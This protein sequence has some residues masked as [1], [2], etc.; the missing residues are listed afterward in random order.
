MNRKTKHIAI[1]AIILILSIFGGIALYLQEA[2]LPQNGALPQLQT[3]EPAEVIIDKEGYFHLYARNNPD[4]Y[5][6]LGYLH[7][8]RY[9]VK[10]DL[11]QRTA[12]GTLSEAF[13]ADYL[14]IDIFSRT[15]GFADIAAD[16]I[17]RIDPAERQ[18]MSAY[19][20]GINTYINHNFHR[21]P[22]KFKF[23]RYKPSYWKPED[24]LAI[25]RL[26]AWALSDQLTK[27]VV[28]YKLLEIYGAAKIRDGFPAVDNLPPITFPVHN[29]QF[30]AD[31][32]YFVNSH[33]KML[34]MLNITVEDLEN[35][36]ALSADRTV[37]N[38]PALGGELPDFLNDYHDLLELSA[39][40]IQ[41]SGL[42]IP[43]IP[44]VLTGSNADI[45]WNLTIRPGDNLEFILIPG[46]ENSG[47]SGDTPR[48]FSLRQERIAIRNAADTTITV[49]ETKFGPIIN[50]APDFTGND[51]ELAIYW[52]G[53][54][55]SNDLQCFTRLYSAQS[56][57]DFKDAVSWHIVPAAE[58]DYLDI[59]NNIG[60]AQHIS[61]LEIDDS[62]KRLYTVS[63]FYEPDFSN[64][65]QHL[66]RNLNPQSVFI[67]HYRAFAECLP[68]S[69]V[70]EDP[71]ATDSLLS[72]QEILSAKENR[73]AKMLLPL[74]FEIISPADCN[75][76]LQRQ[77]YDI[78]NQWNYQSLESSPAQTVYTILLN[79]L[80][81][82]TFKDEMQLA[83]SRL[84][85]QFAHLDDEMFLNLVCLLQ[86]GESS[87]FDD[88]R[89][90][91]V[92]ERR[93][94]IV[95]KAFTETVNFLSERYSPNIS[96]WVPENILPARQIEST[97][98]LLALTSKPVIY[99]SSAKVHQSHFLSREHRIIYR[100]SQLQAGNRLELI[101]QG[102]RI[103]TVP[104]K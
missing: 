6:T 48:D 88:I 67:R 7:A 26:L 37:E 65:V 89:T 33:L 79:R 72:F 3:A 93:R 98:F 54:Q 62:V 10:M 4:L 27:K 69:I 96:Q 78:L 94:D 2:R 86:K 103:I 74:I 90:E 58:V 60:T 29:T 82:L 11:F 71:F 95:L 24:C 14:D 34:D 56:W 36:W 66:F 1:L 73:K 70:G 41:I 23:R 35:S 61:D 44:F 77:V 19:C 8:A 101:Q 53:F 75:N 55:F 63:R 99:T 46:P 81:E 84:Y 18:I 17:E 57:Q 42:V 50:R 45:A 59:Y 40:G 13:G 80:Y 15:V 12:R 31:L 47:R 87:W 30:F 102:A 52:G 32:D 64:P 20:D 68:D 9:L 21:L 51:Y 76:P 92:I 104:A 49:R 38:V 91:T 43:G 39:P 85:S 25:Q 22:A 97:N 5:K 28:F 83:D 100:Q 16:F